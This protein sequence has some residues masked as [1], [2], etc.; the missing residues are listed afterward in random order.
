VGQLTSVTIDGVLTREYVY[1]DNGNRLQFVD[2]EAGTTI[3]G[4]YDDRD[5]LL[6]YGDFVYTY[7]DRGQLSSKTDTSTGDA[8]TY[9]YDVL[10]NLLSV[11]LP[12][13]TLIEYLV[14]GNGRRVGKKRDGVLE[15]QWVYAMTCASWRSW[16]A[17]GRW[18]RGLFGRMTCCV[19]RMTR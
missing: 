2:H 3:E 14:D 13:A 1:D 19:R 15:K 11:T 6:S 12:D 7:N 16:M 8:T 17:A 5:R 9:V 4:V 18:W 10:G